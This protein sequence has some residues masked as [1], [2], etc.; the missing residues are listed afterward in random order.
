M[1]N[2][3]TRAKKAPASRPSPVSKPEPLEEPVNKYAPKAR[4]GSEKT[5]SAPGAKV[6]QVGLGKLK[7]IQY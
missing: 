1:P 5:V 7:V 2:Q 6:E 3:K 4:V